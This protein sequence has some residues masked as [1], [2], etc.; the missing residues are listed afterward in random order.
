M[1]LSLFCWPYNILFFCLTC[2][3]SI[4]S[5]S[6]SPLIQLTINFLSLWEDFFHFSLILRMA[7]WLLLTQDSIVCAVHFLKSLSELECN[8]NILL[9]LLALCFW[10]LSCCLAFFWYISLFCISHS[11]INWDKI[12]STTDTP[13]TYL[14]LLLLSVLCLEVFS[15]K[16]FTYSYESFPAKT[17][18]IQYYFEC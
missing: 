15:S 10:I 1:A 18:L 5:L 8:M 7:F 14:S 6:F 3:W 13:Q 2:N 4:T 16:N 9:G 11:L 17:C 12:S